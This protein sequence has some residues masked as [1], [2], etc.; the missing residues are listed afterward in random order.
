MRSA[1]TRSCFTR[2]TW[3]Y[4]EKQGGL[5]AGGAKS[6]LISTQLT[7]FC[8]LRLGTPVISNV[9]KRVPDAAK[10]STSRIRRERGMKQ[11]SMLRS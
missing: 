7:A 3:V 9:A 11:N 4:V 6:V 1:L 2:N 5:L 8:K 10:L